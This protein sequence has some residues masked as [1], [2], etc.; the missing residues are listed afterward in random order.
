MTFSL[1]VLRIV[2]QI[3]PHNCCPIPV[4]LAHNLTALLVPGGP[5]LHGEQVAD[6]IALSTETA[7]FGADRIRAD[8]SV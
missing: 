5:V 1:N 7:H 2:F 4:D 6:N 8:W 3:W